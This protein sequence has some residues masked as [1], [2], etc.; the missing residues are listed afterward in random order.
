MEP[1]VMSQKLIELTQRMAN[2]DY[3]YGAD[4][5]FGDEMESISVSR[6]GNLVD[7][8]FPLEG[9]E[10]E[11]LINHAVVQCVG[12]ILSKDKVSENKKKARFREYGLYFLNESGLNF[13]SKWYRGIKSPMWTPHIEG[14]IVFDD[15]NKFNYLEIIANYYSE[16]ED[17][18]LGSLNGLVR[19]KKSDV[20][21]LF[22]DGRHVAVEFNRNINGLMGKNTLK[23]NNL[24]SE[25][26]KLAQEI[27][28]NFFF[29]RLE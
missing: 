16:T 26:V 17:N 9:V 29:Y 13:S 12:V 28:Q 15:D 4:Y 21:Y 7:I 25:H 27:L 19:A 18:S 14:E 24:E 10:E 22:G 6:G 5:I 3:D 20:K 8:V 2:I 23:I 11:S 1:E